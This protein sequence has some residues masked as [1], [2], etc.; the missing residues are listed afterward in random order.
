MK[1]SL[2]L[3]VGIMLLV[4][5]TGLFAATEWYG[6]FWGDAEGEWKGTLYDKEVLPP[7]FKGVWTDGHHEGELY[8][9]L[10]YAGHGVYKIVKGLIFNEYGKE[11]GKWDGYFDQNIKPG[12]AEGEW[13][14]LEAD[15]S[16]K[17]Q[18]QRVL[19]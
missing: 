4:S 6:K 5:A 7:C 17:W 13:K 8:A 10:E 16:G 19:P 15:L 2:L 12:Y 11:I 3:V 1:K 18:G 14:L 9:E